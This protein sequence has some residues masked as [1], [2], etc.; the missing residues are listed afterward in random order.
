[1]GLSKNNH[2]NLGVE[3]SSRNLEYTI[4][5]QYKYQEELKHQENKCWSDFF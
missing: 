5:L 1:M 2:Y 3:T 4:D